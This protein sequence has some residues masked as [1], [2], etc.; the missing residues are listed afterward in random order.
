SRDQR[1]IVSTAAADND[2]SVVIGDLITKGCE[3]SSGAG[4]SGLNRHNNLGEM[5]MHTVHI[6]IESVNHT[7]RSIRIKPTLNVTSL[8]VEAFSLNLQPL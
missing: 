4:V 1:H 7:G 6:A 3:V 8:T 5:Y 2:Y